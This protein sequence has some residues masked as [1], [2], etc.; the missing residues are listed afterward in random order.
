MPDTT[1]LDIFVE[2]IMSINVMRMGGA[3]AGIVGSTGTD[4]DTAN[5]LKESTINFAREYNKSTLNQ[6][7]L[8]RLSQK[9]MA[10]Y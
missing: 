7:K 8:T 4:G 10:I 1:K 9:S 3:F 6:D 2:K 5:N